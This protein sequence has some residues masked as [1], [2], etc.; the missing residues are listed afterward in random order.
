MVGKEDEDGNRLVPWV[1]ELSPLQL[2]GIIAERLDKEFGGG[3][4]RER[5][6]HL[7]ENQGAII[8][9]SGAKRTPY[10]CS[11]CPHNTST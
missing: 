9:I 10:F 11:G 3:T 2:A 7:R 6:Q 4:Y 5:A 8:E 1:G